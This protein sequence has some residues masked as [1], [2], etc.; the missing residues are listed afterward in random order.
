[1]DIQ[2]VLKSKMDEASLQKLTALNNEEVNAFVA[3]AIELCEP[4]TVWVGTDSDEDVPS[5]ISNSSRI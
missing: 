3:H 1:M 4:E 5:T 2:S